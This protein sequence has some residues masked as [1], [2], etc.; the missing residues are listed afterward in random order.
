MD[1]ISLGNQGTVLVNVPSNNIIL[2]GAPGPQGPSGESTIAGSVITISN[3]S[4]N[5]LLS[6]NGSNWTNRAQNLVTEGGNF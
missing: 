3:L 4:A 1:I 5:D 2:A 6:F